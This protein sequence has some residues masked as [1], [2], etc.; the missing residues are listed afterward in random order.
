MLHELAPTPAPTTRTA[1]DHPITAR[2]IA[3]QIGIIREGAL[4]DGTAAVVTGERPCWAQRG[5]ARP[6]LAWPA[7][8][9]DTGLAVRRVCHCLLAPLLLALAGEGAPT[10]SA[11]AC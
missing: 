3:Q 8:S 11:A 4:E 1:G 10:A 6:G 5:L 2:A 9:A 7:C